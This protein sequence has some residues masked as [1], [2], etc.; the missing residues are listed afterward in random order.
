[1]KKIIFALLLTICV[2]MC[3]AQDVYFSSTFTK[4]KRVSAD[5]SYTWSTEVEASIRVTLHGKMVLVNDEAESSY[6]C[7]K[8]LFSNKKDGVEQTA[9]MA[10]DEENRACIIKLAINETTGT[11]DLYVMYNT[12]AFCYGDLKQY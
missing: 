11:M 6:R 1:M 9:W 5:D 4:G 3:Y 2:S 10:R 12:V 8:E 7:G